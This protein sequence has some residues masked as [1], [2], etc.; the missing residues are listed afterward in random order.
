MLRF[1]LSRVSSRHPDLHR[2]DAARVLPHPDRAGRSDRNHGGRARH[3]RR[4]PRGAAQGIRARPAGA[5]PVRHLHRPRASRRPRQVDDHAGAGAARVRHAVPRDHR[6]RHL[7]DPVRA[8]HRH[9][10]GN[11]RRG[12]AQLGV[13]PWRDGRV[14]HR[15]F[16]A[17]LLVGAPADPALL[18]AAGLDAGVRPH[19]GP[20]RR[21]AGDR[22]PADRLAPVRRQGRLQVG[23]CRI[24]SCR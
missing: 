18:G 23:A 9:S 21:P 6:A 16:D 2:H 10:R 22:L 12:A 4:A 13:R 17:D 20:V 19:R 8:H 24:S 11:D 15:L 5:R 3:R 7:R 14:A 1:L